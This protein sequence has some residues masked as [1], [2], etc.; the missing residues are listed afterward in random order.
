MKRE[1]HAVFGFPV[2]WAPT[3]AYFGLEPQKVDS[4]W[5]SFEFLLAKL[6]L[7]WVMAES[8]GNGSP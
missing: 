5:A 1:D 6:S 8:Q 3:K 2:C 4:Y 7:H